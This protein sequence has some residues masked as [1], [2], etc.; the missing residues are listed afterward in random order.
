M[1]IN[2]IN[3]LIDINKGKSKAISRS[4]HNLNDEHTKYCKSVMNQ[5]VKYGLIDDVVSMLVLLL[6]INIMTIL[7]YK[8]P[9]FVSCILID[10]LLISSLPFI[11]FT[12]LFYKSEK[13]IAKDR[14]RLKSETEIAKKSLDK[15]YQYIYELEN[16]KSKVNDYDNQE[17]NELCKVIE[18]NPVY[19][20]CKSVPDNKELSNKNSNLT[21]KL[22]KVLK[23]NQ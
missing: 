2:K 11:D 8:G 6:G 23:I 20:N 9:G 4:I 13:L 14:N 18:A 1:N 22:I 21:S 19:Y 16:I 3:D 10:A 5:I 17:V 7:L 12:V 15:C